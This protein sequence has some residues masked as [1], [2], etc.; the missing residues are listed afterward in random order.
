MDRF[1]QPQLSQRDPEDQRF[2]MTITVIV[3]RTTPMMFSQM[4]PFTM[5]PIRT[6]PDPNAMAFGRVATGSMKAQVAVSAT[7]M[8]SSMM[9][10]LMP[11]ATPPHD[12]QEGRRGRGAGGHLGQEDD[13]GEDDEHRGRPTDLFRALADPRREPVG[14]EH[15]GEG[16]SARRTAAGFT[17]AP[18]TAPEPEPRPPGGGTAVVLLDDDLTIVGQTAGSDEWLRLLLPQP[19]DRRPIPACAYKRRRATPRS[20]VRRRRPRT[21]GPHAAAHRRVGHPLSRA[22]RTSGSR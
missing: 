9:S 1:A 5:S 7:G 4:P 8:T 22:S 12:R 21:H 13:E 20:G 11:P 6:Y 10:W 16:Q 2:P 18:P 15:R 3:M 19:G 14:G 17:P